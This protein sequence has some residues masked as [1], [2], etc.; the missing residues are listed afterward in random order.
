MKAIMKTSAGPGAQ[1]CE[2]PEPQITRSDQIKVR[3][4]ATSIPG[5]TTISIVGIVVI[6][7]CQAAA[8]HGA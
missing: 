7:P 4:Q 3:V 8:H 6:R 5:Q 1:I 2:V